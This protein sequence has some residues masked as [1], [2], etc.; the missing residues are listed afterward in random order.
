MKSTKRVICL[1]LGVLICLSG[2]T[3][4]PKYDKPAALVPFTW[5]TGE[6]YE[7]SMAKPGAKPAAEI[8]WWEFFADPKL[9][10]LI[11]T[12]LQNNLDLRKA[13]LNVDRAR[14]VYGIQ[15]AELNAGPQRIRQ[16]L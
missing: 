13:A 7:D 9:Q 11:E 1:S 12:A 15:R 14:A 8:H 16:L 10:K 3:L 4:A 6:A 2:C 5:P